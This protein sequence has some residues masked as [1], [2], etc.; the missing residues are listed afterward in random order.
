MP[1]DDG[2]FL[3]SDE[4]RTELLRLEPRCA[5]YVKPLISTKQ[6]LNGEKRWCLWLHEADPVDVRKIPA[7][8]ERVE[9]VR[10]YRRKSKRKTTKALAKTPMLFGEIRQPEK[11]YLLVPRHSSERRDYIPL[12]FLKPDHIV[13]DSCMFVA[14]ASL[15]H[16]GVLHSTMHMAWV[17]QVGGRI[18]SDYR[19]SA[20]L[21]YNN[22]P[23]PDKPSKSQ[24]EEVEE[25]VQEVLAERA[26][27]PGASL[28][29]LY[30]PLTMPAGLRKAHD[31][32]DRAVD[33]CY[34]KGAFPDERRRFEYLYDLWANTLGLNVGTQTEMVL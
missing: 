2:Q 26:K 14:E 4:E 12:A 18:K 20:R 29:D 13:S 6:F 21:V 33:R 9:A 19:Y 34:R 30:D 25:S 24:I 16:F 27:H 23:W 32:L 3:L 22:F 28:S 5:P 31:R 17:R 1:N 15:F 7:L 11:E 10:K 8:I